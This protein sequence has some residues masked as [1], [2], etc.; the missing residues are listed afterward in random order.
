MP[1]PTERDDPTVIF[2]AHRS[3]LFAIAYRM[4][5]S[6][7]DAEDMVQ[8]AFLRWRTA[9]HAEIEIPGAWLSTAVTRLSLNS[10]Q[11]SKNKREVYVG[12]WLPEPLPTNAQTPVDALELAD[13]MSIAFLAIMERLNPRERAVF[14]LRDVFDFDYEEIARIL[15][16]EVTNCRQLFHRAKAR[17]RQSA[18]RFRPDPK[19]HRELL[20][21]FA[22][23]VRDGD[24]DRV[25]QL[26]ARDA[27]LYVDSGGAVRAA[28]RRPVRG[29]L[30]VAQFL[31]GVARKVAPP[32]LRIHAIEVNGEPALVSEVNGVPQQVVTIVVMRNRIRAVNIVANPAKL[33]RVR[34]ELARIL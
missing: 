10:L 12:P 30:R 11:S 15:D 16:V 33:Q 24:V 7:E 21:Q 1:T 18:A 23:A 2:E 8:D 34:A 13:S 14:L 31:A 27:V 17:L 25:V 29:A 5:G 28:A 3:R 19:A 22:G 32:A 4:L 20:A 26:L 6:V 9:N